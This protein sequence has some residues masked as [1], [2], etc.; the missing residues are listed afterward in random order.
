MVPDRPLIPELTIRAFY[1]LE[2]DT[3]LSYLIA[4][5]LPDGRRCAD[6]CMDG[7]LEEYL[8]IAFKEM[9][10]GEQEQDQGTARG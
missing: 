1:N 5:T 2:G 6:I 7:K 3:I 4:Y 10:D 8:A 9:T